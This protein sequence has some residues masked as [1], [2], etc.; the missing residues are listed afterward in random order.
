MDLLGGR[1]WEVLQRA[2][3]AYSLRQRVIAHNVANLNTPGY[4][5]YRVGF[6]EELR[7][8]LSRGDLSLYRTH[9]RHLDPRPALEEVEP[10]VVRETN[11][12]SRPDGNNVDLTE[13]MV[14]LAANQLCYQVAAQAASG[15]LARLRLVI[16]GG[17]R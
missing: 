12:S 9:P 3:A 17:R 15:Y 13:Q 2:L 10:R 5:K 14:Q 1:N 11:T 7:A 8:A 16:T 4:K 6:E